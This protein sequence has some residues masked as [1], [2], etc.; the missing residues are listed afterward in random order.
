MLYASIDIETSGLDH[1]FCQILEIGVVLDDLD[2][3]QDPNPPTFHAYVRHNRIQGEVF[4]LAMNKD[5]LQTLADNKHPDIYTPEN[6]K[7]AFRKFLTQHF[8]GDKITPA[9]KNFHGF[10]KHFFDK[11]G[12]FDDEV[13]LHHR[14]F[15]PVTSFYRKGDKKL[16]DL[17]QCLARANTGQE[18]ALHTAVDDCKAVIAL[19]RH[20]HP[21]G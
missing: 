13:A 5:I 12:Y 18:L 2:K 9:G 17:K 16:P 20:I 6:A 7:E 11:E 4:A 15:D 8:K 14:C 1:T 19:L 10:D 21:L 3:P